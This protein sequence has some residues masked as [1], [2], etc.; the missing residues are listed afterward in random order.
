MNPKPK[1]KAKDL[2]HYKLRD[3]ENIKYRLDNDLPPNKGWGINLLPENWFINPN[4]NYIT[5]S[6]KRVIAMELKLY[7]DQGSEVTF[8]IKGTIVERE[9]PLKT[10]YA[11]WTLDGRAT[12]WE[13]SQDDL[14]EV[15]EEASLKG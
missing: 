14:F 7:N 9:K 12:I 8:P 5:R 15:D 1:L 10:R 2:A 11:I 4:L 3:K 6:G 13:T